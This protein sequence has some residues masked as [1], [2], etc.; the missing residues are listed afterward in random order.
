MND[1]VDESSYMD[2]LT[3]EGPPWLIMIRFRVFGLYDG[4]MHSVD[5]AL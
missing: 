2:E 3:M 1:D 5:I 4:N